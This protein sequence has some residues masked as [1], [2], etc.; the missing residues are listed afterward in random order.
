MA[1]RPNQ[2]SIPNPEFGVDFDASARAMHQSA[3]KGSLMVHE[4]AF[5]MP[6]VARKSLAATMFERNTM[7]KTLKRKIAL[8]AVAALGSA[9]LAVIAAPA[10]NAAAADATSVAIT[11]V[12]VSATGGVQ[13]VV[14]NASLSF[15]TPN[16]LTDGAGLDAFTLTV[17]TAPTST[18]RSTTATS[19]S[20]SPSC[21]AMFVWQGRRAR[22]ACCRTR[23]WPTPLARC[24][25]QPSTRDRP[26]SR[27]K[28]YDS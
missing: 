13:D 28:I 21:T 15:V 4:T 24:S 7:L 3:S 14:P 17:T 9:G 18:R 12:R 26:R 16:E 25:T 1:R 6:A 23:M 11:P 19:T 2:V 8:V 5:S 27:T 20:T 22:R 10:A